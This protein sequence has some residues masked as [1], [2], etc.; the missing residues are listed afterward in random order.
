MLSRSTKSGTAENFNE[1]RFE[2]KK[3]EEQVFIHAEK[4]FE[5]KVKNNDTLIVGKSGAPDGSQ[6][7]EIWKDRSAEVKTGN[8][9]TKVTK[10]NHSVKVDVGTSTIEAAQKITLKVGAST[11]TI[12][13]AQIS[14]SSPNISVDGKAKVAA[15]APMTDIK[16]SATL[17]LGGTIVKI[18]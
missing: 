13:P 4:D 18:N 10:G 17:M 14:I 9:S 1:L 11:I 5:R 16:G 2:D 7:I 12:E 15:T 6:K 8:D 3:G